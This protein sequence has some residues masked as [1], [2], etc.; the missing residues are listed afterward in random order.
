MLVNV[1]GN[2]AHTIVLRIA[3]HKTDACYV[4]TVTLHEPV[5]GVHGE[6]FTNVIPQILAVTTGTTT[7]TIGDVDGKGHLV[8][9]LLKDDVGI[10]IFK[11]YF[12]ILPLF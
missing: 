8:R 3:A 5:N 10:Y 12:L 2:L 4:A 1:F 7:R 11:H 6:R 9:N